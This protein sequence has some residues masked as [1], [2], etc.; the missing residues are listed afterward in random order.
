MCGEV[1]WWQPR[2]TLAHL[3]PHLSLP[4]RIFICDYHDT[5][6]ALS[7][8]LALTSSPDCVSGLWSES[9]S[10]PPGTTVVPDVDTVDV[11]QPSDLDPIV[12][13][14]PS[15]VPSS[16]QSLVSSYFRF[17]LPVV[18]CITSPEHFSGSLPF[19]RL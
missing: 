10:P 12:L 19:L 8:Y 5:K 13:S 1:L 15:S 18:R 11:N 3:S 2:P 16:V 6:I 17:G 7:F 4:P 9:V 14:L